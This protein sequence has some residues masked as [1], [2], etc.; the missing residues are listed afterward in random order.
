MMPK[1][2]HQFDMMGENLKLVRKRR[3]LTEEMVAERAGID[4]E[5]LLLLEDGYAEVS[6]KKLF[7]VMNVYGMGGEIGTL[8]FNDILGRTLQDIELLKRKDI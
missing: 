2:Q 8:C 7:M 4:I 1:Y 5:T 3:K 6:I